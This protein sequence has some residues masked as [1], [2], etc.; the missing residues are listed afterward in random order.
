LRGEPEKLLANLT[1]KIGLTLE[2]GAAL[3]G[4]SDRYE[5]TPWAQRMVK[6]GERINPA[7]RGV[8]R[9]LNLI[10]YPDRQKFERVQFLA[11]NVNERQRDGF[12][13]ALHS[14]RHQPDILISLRALC[15]QQET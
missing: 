2:V 11:R 1:P 6:T 5:G 4:W 14:L 10:V 13:P 8:R 12:E 9:W 7:F 15:L 3:V